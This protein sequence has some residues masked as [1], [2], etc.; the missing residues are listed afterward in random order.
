MA[1]QANK[2]DSSVVMALSELARMEQDRIESD[3][4]RE[5][6]RIAAAKAERERAEAAAKEA[7]RA[8]AEKEAREARVVEA[9]ARMRVEA[10]RE[11]DQRIAAMR[12]ELARVES[13]R[14]NLRVDL[15]SRLTTREPSRPSGWAMAFGLSSLVAASLAGLLVFQST[16]DV[17]VEPVAHASMPVLAQPAVTDVVIPDAL[18]T[19]AID[20]EEEPE[21][22]VAPAARPHHRHDRTQTEDHETVTTEHGHGTDLVGLD[23][24]DGSDDVL[25]NLATTTLHH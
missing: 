25:G 1:T 11:R 2:S 10:D 14:Q 16:H 15:E 4:A 9:E 8:R 12:A 6:E 13:E 20:R 22:A 17:P 3:R 19:Q 18:P 7:E 24:V 21:V 5:A 23:G